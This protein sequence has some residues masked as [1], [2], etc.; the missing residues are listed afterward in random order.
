MNEKDEL[1][2]D[3]YLRGELSEEATDA[4]RQRLTTDNE[5][6]ERLEFEQ[7][8]FNTLGEDSWHFVDRDEPKVATYKA[9]FQSA[10]AQALKDSIAEAGKNYK[11]KQKKGKSRSMWT[12][13]VAASV[14]LVI[15]FFMLRPGS[16]TTDALYT[17]YLA[18]TELPD[19]TSR[20][21]T[22]DSEE[23]ARSQTLF[24]ERN[25]EEAAMAYSELLAKGVQLSGIYINLSLSQV[26]LEQYDE[27]LATLDA[28]INSNLIDAQKGYWFKALVYLKAGD[29]A[30][31]KKQLN[32]I[33]DQGLYNKELASELLEEL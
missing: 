11:Q 12:Y 10:E 19:L 18:Q 3:Q 7:E 17:D 30:E 13:A 31:A 25:Y 9:D 33:V 20:S 8:L 4:F 27:A 16:A 1:L 26:A 6:K 24:D 15:S 2:I 29:S 5:L 21:S 28:L 32:Q 22:N 14:V 23:L